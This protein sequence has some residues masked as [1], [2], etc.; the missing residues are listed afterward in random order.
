MKSP[1]IVFRMFNEAHSQ[2]DDQQKRL[3]AL[4]AKNDDKVMF[5]SK[6]YADTY[7]YF[8]PELVN[9]CA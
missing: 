3:D 5:G 1:L 6:D 2:I 9:Y 8:N 4:D 7:F